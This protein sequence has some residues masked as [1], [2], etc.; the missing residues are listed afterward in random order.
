MLEKRIV[1]EKIKKM[2]LE[3][4]KEEVL[5]ESEAIYWQILSS[6]LLE[7]SKVIMSYM[8]FKNEVDTEKLNNYIISLQKKLLLPKMIDKEN[9]EAIEYNG[10]FE[11][12]NSFGIK[13]PVGKEYLEEIDLV[14]VPGIAFNLKG[15]RIGYGRGYYDRFLKKYPKA[16]K[17]SLAYEFQ[18]IDSFTAENYDE[19]IDEIVTKNNIIKTKKY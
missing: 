5:K 19:K 8:S 14:I 11:I 16:K 6:E 3:L 9:I 2:R 1:R 18:I 10:E 13:E 15:D 17:I 4:S 7:K 12:K